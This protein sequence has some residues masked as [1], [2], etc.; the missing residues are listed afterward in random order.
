[1]TLTTNNPDQQMRPSNIEQDQAKSHCVAKVALLLVLYVGAGHA[2]TRSDQVLVKDMVAGAQTVRSEGRDTIVDYSYV[3]RRPRDKIHARWRLDASGI[4]QEYSAHGQDGAG[5]PIEEHF[6]IQ[7]GRANWN[8]R[9]GRFSTNLRGAAFY[10]PA[11]PPPEIINVLARALLKA[12]EHKLQL[13]PAGAASIEPAAAADLEL[14]HGKHK[15]LLQYRISGLEFHPISVWLD[16]D[17]EAS[18]RATD[19]LSVLPREWGISVAPLLAAADASDAAW[20][21]EIASRLTHTP[22]G[23]LVIRHARLF[24]PRDLTVTASMSVEIS[25]EWIVRVEPDDTLQPPPGAEVIDAHGS[26]LMPGLWDNHQHFEGVHGALDL[27]CGITS[28]RDMANDTD[29]FLQRVARFDAGTELGPRVFKA[30]VI[31]GNGP[32]AAPTKMRPE[33]PQEAMADVDWYVAHGYGQ[34]KIYSSARPALVAGIADEAHAHGL[35]VSGHVPTGM[36]A[37][38]FIAA[39]A[40]EI[41][42]LHYVATDLL[43]VLGRNPGDGFLA[44]FGPR[45][46]GID[47]S[48]ARAQDYIAM[49]AR[50]HIVLDPT[51]ALYEGL[52]GG[53]PAEPLPG[54]DA[55]IARFPASVRTQFLS[56]AFNIPK[57][58]EDAYH[59]AFPALLQLLAAL[60]A[61]GVTIIPGTDSL[62]GYGLHRELEVYVEAGIPPAEALRMATLTSARVSG[63]SNERGVVAAG[64]RADFILIDGD[65][66][67]RI[68]DLARVHT[69]FK[70]G[71]RFETAEI[72]RAL[73]ISPMQ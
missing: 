44:D 30:G 73:G 39:G 64:K 8:N 59:K 7:N 54:L 2:A 6:A 33:T 43:R 36:N 58:Q 1:M 10:L 28:A 15:H 72:E 40:D 22:H 60:H 9:F 32:G 31:D 69:V 47:V 50:R 62:P 37:R 5:A 41:Q 38:Q 27:A 4:P 3:D 66:T 52:Y 45:A 19:W 21:A 57:G 56:G 68:D 42:H 16:P 11:T 61:A 65:P 49:L 13:L 34:I 46:A 55:I 24:D 67:A 51:V 29:I 12:P 53:N 23:P 48:D 18:A 26:F 20:S 14:G 17:G 71:K 25:G 35:R 63:V 70:G